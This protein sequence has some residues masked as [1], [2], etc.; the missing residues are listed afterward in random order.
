VTA[1]RPDSRAV[2]RTELDLGANE[3]RQFSNI[4]AQMG[5]PTVYNARLSVRV[6]GGAG[7]LTAYSSA[8]DNRTDDAIFVA[9]K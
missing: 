2:V 1:V 8:I 7:R 9:A 4:L 3:F 5:L 6:I